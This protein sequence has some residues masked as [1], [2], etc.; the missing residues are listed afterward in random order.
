LKPGA[1]CGDTLWVLGN[2]GPRLSSRAR[3]AASYR[4]VEIRHRRTPDDVVIGPA[5]SDLGVE[6]DQ[7]LDVVVHY[8]EASAGNRED[9]GKFLQ[10]SVDPDPAI[11]GPL[12]EQERPAHAVPA[13]RDSGTTE[14]PRDR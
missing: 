9:L 7:H 6:W 2:L 1:S 3:A 14:L 12:P 5:R 11:I 4:V 13:R 10:P 8:G